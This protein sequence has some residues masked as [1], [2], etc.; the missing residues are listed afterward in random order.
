MPDFKYGRLI[1]RGLEK[2]NLSTYLRWFRD[3]EVTQNLG[4]PMV[5]YTL[6][7]EEGWM[8]AELKRSMDERTMGIHIQKEGSEELRLIGNGGFHAIDQRSRSAEI[9]LLIGEKA[10]WNKGY[11]TEAVQGLI[12]HG[13][14]N[15]GLHR[16]WLR[17]HSPNRGGIRAYE[18]AGMKHEGTLREAH[19]QQGRFVDVHIMS[20]LREE[21]DEQEKR[22]VKA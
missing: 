5:P 15:L 16:I 8:E 1:F 21:W 12:W 13:F 7:D 11:G 9:G 19:Y 17:V 20:I 2:A 6:S 4:T 18:K 3:A 22:K 10:E 14:Y